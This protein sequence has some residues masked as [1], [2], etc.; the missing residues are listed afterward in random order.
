MALRRALEV[1]S[2]DGPNFQFDCPHC[3]GLG[4]FQKFPLKE[5]SDFLYKSHSV[6][7]KRNRA[8]GI[9]QCPNIECSGLVFFV[10]DSTYNKILSIFPKIIMN[11][12]CSNFPAEVRSHFEQAVICA[13]EECYIASAIMVRR[14]LEEVC[15]TEKCDGKNLHERLESFRDKIILPN[16]LLNAAFE[17]KL[18]GNDAAHVKSKNYINMGREEISVAIRLTHKIL[19]ALYQS[20][21]LLEQLLNLK[22]QKNDR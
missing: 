21:E 17:L 16:N 2:F 22:E 12:D 1:T 6:I 4:T 19:E 18:L 11:Y 5:H 20:E 15:E 10:Y 13:S 8:C 9:R 14:T 7:P 3:G